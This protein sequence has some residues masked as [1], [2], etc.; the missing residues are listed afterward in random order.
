M[1]QPTIGTPE[2]LTF[3]KP[4]VDVA[5]KKLTDRG[6]LDV[7]SFGHNSYCYPAKTQVVAVAKSLWP[8][9][10]WAYTAHNGTLGGA[11]GTGEGKV[12]MPIKY[13]VCVWTEGRLAPRGGRAL[14]K[15]RPSI[16]CDTARTRHRDWSPL[17]VIRNL[18]EEVIQRGHDGVGDFG[19][20]LFP[21]KK[22]KG[23]FY[24]LGN[25][26]GTG[27]PND[28]Q[29]AILAP[30]PDGAVST[31][32]FENFREGVELSEAVLFLEKTLQDKKL[33]GELEQKVNRYLDERGEVFTKFWYDRGFA[34][35]N[36]WAP[37]G[38]ADRDARLLALCAEVAAATGGK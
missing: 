2:S 1:E 15:P 17:I 32:R 38:L 37:A 16:W 24:C 31:E 23:G 7:S 3:W 9:G 26:R 8:D 18:P 19:S 4:V 12:S 20:D 27:G 35:I 13:S 22:E 21:V 6:W 36:A 33:S 30:G 11:W 25:G 14:L 28:A 34:F 29:R 10:V 5:L